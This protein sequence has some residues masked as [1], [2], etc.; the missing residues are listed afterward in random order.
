MGKRIL[1]TEEQLKHLI[2][3]IDEGNNV[4]EQ[5]N[6]FRIGDIRGSFGTTKNKNKVKD[7]KNDTES[8]G[9][10]DDKQL[11]EL[12]Y[13]KF[14]T[15]LG[16]GNSKRF[17]NLPTN[18]KE[19]LMGVWFKE[20][21]LPEDFFK[22]S[23][24]YAFQIYSAGKP[25]HMKILGGYTGEVGKK[26]LETVEQAYIN[27]NL[28]NIQAYNGKSNT[29]SYINVYPATNQKTPF[30]PIFTPEGELDIRQATLD[31]YQLFIMAPGIGTG[32]EAQLS[33]TKS[34]P[35]TS[36]T[37]TVDIPAIPVSFATQSDI[38]SADQVI[39]LRD[40]LFDYFNK[41]AK[42]KYA[43]DNGINFEISNINVIS[44]ASNSWRGNTLPYT[45]ESDGSEA[46]TPYSQQY[47]NSN[48]TIKG[49]SDLNLALSQRR[50]QN[51]ENLLES[52]P[53]FRNVL[54][55]NE[56]TTLSSKGIVTNTGGF[57]DDA[58]N[59]PAN[60]PFGQFAKFTFTVKYTEE[61]PGIDLQNFRINNFI[62][63][64]I[65]KKSSTGNI[66]TRFFDARKAKIL[67]PGGGWKAPWQI[68]KNIGKNFSGLNIFD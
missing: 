59:R 4:E 16:K 28:Q 41:N 50:G 21:G 53:E 63:K 48:S 67:R 30:Q 31:G 47:N 54:K 20:G 49:Y 12:F 65:K 3:I 1:V 64:L 39:N 22:N 17:R 57:V 58:P 15:D 44:S 5:V 61:K 37:F 62:I 36:E 19:S 51:F 68:A 27:L 56:K 10:D 42:I 9:D 8:E 34:T 14:V 6:K 45:N 55:I 52:N 11:A 24:D 18:L 23:G 32:D 38:L 60:T 43:I 66:F 26:R 13:E 25:F 29:Y 35:G 7:S 33:Q 40:K 46:K 2:R